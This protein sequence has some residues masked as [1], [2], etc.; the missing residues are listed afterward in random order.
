[1]SDDHFQTQFRRFTFDLKPCRYTTATGTASN[2]DFTVAAGFATINPGQSVH[3][4]EI[5]ITDD[6][7][8]EASEQFTLSL[9]LRDAANTEI[10]NTGVTTITIVDNDR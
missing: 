10:G 5:A 7:F 2:A 3:N 8:V 6:S 1:M 4:I 9:Q